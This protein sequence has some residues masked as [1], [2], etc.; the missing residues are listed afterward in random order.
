MFWRF[1]DKSQLLLLH[2]L[3]IEHI[4][5]PIS[6]MYSAWLAVQTQVIFKTENWL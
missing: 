4:F 5:K 1:L 2:N 6:S 3:V